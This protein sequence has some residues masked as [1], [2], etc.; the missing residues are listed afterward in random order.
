MQSCRVQLETGRAEIEMEDPR[1][2]LNEIYIVRVC[3]YLTAEAFYFVSLILISLSLATIASMKFL[4]VVVVVVYIIIIVVVVNLSICYLCVLGVNLHSSFGIY[5]RTR[6][7]TSINCKERM[8][9]INIL[10]FDLFF[11]AEALTSCLRSG[12]L[13]AKN[14]QSIVLFIVLRFLW[15]LGL[16]L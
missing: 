5:K 12:L 16:C 3:V 4:V 11:T 1:C 2:V 13:L 6:P 9:K 10:F 7:V 14:S 15:N 8:F